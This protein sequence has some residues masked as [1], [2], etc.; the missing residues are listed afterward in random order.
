[1]GGGGGG[2]CGR[3]GDRPVLQFSRK[4]YIQSFSACT[5]KE[6]NLDAKKLNIKSIIANKLHYGLIQL[7]FSFNTRNDALTTN[8]SLGIRFLRL[9]HFKGIIGKE[10]ASNPEAR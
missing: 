5:V 3:I 7:E 9:L 8:L 1:M 10:H 6:M 4:F 2:G